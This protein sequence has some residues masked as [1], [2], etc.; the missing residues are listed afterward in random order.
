MIFD[1]A[2]PTGYDWDLGSPNKDFGGPGRGAGGEE[3]QPGENRTPLGN[4]LIL[5]EERDQDDPD[6]YYAGGTLIFTFQEPSKVHEI[7]LLDIDVDEADGTIV[8]FDSSGIKLGVF[9]M[10]PFGNNSV[11]DVLIDLENISRL[12][13]HLESSGAVAAVSF[14]DPDP[15]P[16]DPT[17][18][19]TSEP[20]EETT[21]VATKPPNLSVRSCLVKD[22]DLFRFEIASNGADG[23]YRL[24]A[25][26][27]E[28]LGPWSIKAGETIGGTTEEQALSTELE[29]TW[30]K[31]YL[32]ENGWVNA[33]GTHVTCLQGHRDHGYFC[34]DDDQDPT[35]EPKETLTPDPSPSPDVSETPQPEPTKPGGTPVPSPVGTEDPKSPPSNGPTIDLG[36]AL[37]I[38]EGE[39]FQQVGSIEDPDSKNW[40][41]KV[42]YGFGG[43]EETLIVDDRGRFSLEHIYGDDGA[44]DIRVVVTDDQGN[45][46]SE[47]IKIEVVNVAP[48]VEFVET[49]NSG[50]CEH[51]ED[52]KGTNRN[53]C[54]NSYWATV[55]VGEKVEFRARATDPG[56]DDLT[57]LWNADEP[58]EHFNNGDTPD[59]KLSPGGE[60]PFEA[61]DDFKISFEETG[62]HEVSLI[63]EDDDGGNTEITIGVKV[64]DVRA[65]VGSLGFWKHQFAENGGHQIDD[66]ELERYLDFIENKSGYFNDFWGTISSEDAHKILSFSDN[67]FRAKVR[68]HLLSAWL[69]YAK[70][71]IEWGDKIELDRGGREWRFDRIIAWVEWVLSNSEASTGD[72]QYAKDLAEAVSMLQ[73]ERS[74]CSYEVSKD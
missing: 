8:A 50:D 17:P 61:D 19:V 62:V 51:K 25:Y 12:E 36:P 3:G 33:G 54:G 47:E 31:E 41:A 38:S 2:N 4:V 69:N 35:D 57:F 18:E 46:V 67:D 58:S 11:Q 16:I 14:C 56:S 39:R 42:N 9:A 26:S 60:Y 70:G 10:Q 13:I 29:A 64:I 27:G 23:E 40:T 45:S 21:P 7:Q 34:S 72:F 5:S 73:N 30:L 55:N 48:E 52:D 66:D 43:I 49:D 6:D 65:C 71:S 32:S 59:D 53:D 44:Y 24:R 37:S 68:A 1:S 15:Y 74:K 20:T 63:V 22:E 28:I